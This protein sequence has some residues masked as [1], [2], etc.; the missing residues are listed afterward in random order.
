MEQAGLAHALLFVRIAARP[1]DL[2]LRWLASLPGVLSVM[3]LVGE[4]DAVVSVTLPGMAE[5]SALNDQL[6]VS[7]LIA[8]H[9]SRIVLRHYSA[10]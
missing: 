9:E 10:A 3:S 2:A 4:I 7:D 6:A 5:L 1:C 8:G